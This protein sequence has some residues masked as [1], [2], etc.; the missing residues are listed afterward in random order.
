MK[1]VFDIETDGLY[2]EVTKSHVIVIKEVGQSKTLAFTDN[3]VGDEEGTIADGLKRLGSGTELIGHNIINFDLP[4]LEKLYG[5]KPNEDVK[6]T[7]TLVISRLFNPDRPKPAGYTGKGGPH[8][9]EAWG[10]RVG[11][12]KVDNEEWGV[13]NSN[14]LHRCREDVGINEITYN[15]L[16]AE[17]KGHNWSEALELEHEVARI[18]TEQEIRGVNFDMEK[19]EWLVRHLEGRIQAIDDE[20]LPNLPCTLKQAG[21][22]IQEPFLVKG[23]YRKAVKDWFPDNVDIV[24]GPFSRITVHTI[25]LTSPVQIKKYLLS[26]G[27]VPTEWN[28]KDGEPTSP[29]LTED[30]YSSIPPGLGRSITD[31]SL[32]S[33]RRNQVAGW[34]DRVRQDG[35]VTAAA[36]TIGTPTRRFRHIGLVNV[37]KATHYPK[38]HARVGELVL[39]DDPDFQKVPFGTEMRALFC[40]SVGRKLVGKDAKGIE[41]RM[42]AHYMND[43]AY[44][45]EVVHG[46]IHSANQHAAGLPTRDDAKTF[47]YA[48]LYGA[49]DAKIGSIIGGD[50]KDG[51]ELKR[52]FLDTLPSLDKLIKKVKRASKKGYL[53]GLDGGQTRMRQNEY[54]VATN[55]ALNTLLQCGDAVVMKRDTVILDKLCRHLDVWKVLDM[56][57]ESQYDVLPEEL[58][59]FIELC[60]KAMVQSGESFNLN[61]PMEADVIVGLNWAQTH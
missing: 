18:I 13:Y 26:L 35:R 59:E 17:G 55:K 28:Y 30:S 2:H 51:A 32:F 16:S 4:V 53:K 42:L 50:A 22:S 31:R 49:G 52:Q 27:W 57:D 41:L 24:G 5:W 54:G 6:I 39:C 36:N 14:I 7:D 56:H 34:I 23:G 25:S 60:K 12:A 20:L 45:Y 21:V 11:Q 46:D 1:L 15:I 43:P 61:C 44:T 33:H 3:P 8:S 40:A 29:K 37:P 48:F 47:I 38:E 19:A 58:E 10:H 9:L